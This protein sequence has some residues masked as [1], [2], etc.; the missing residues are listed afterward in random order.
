MVLMFK[1]LEFS[2]VVLSLAEIGPVVLRRKIISG[3]TTDNRRS[4]KIT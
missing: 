4:G 1:N 3:Q 2:C